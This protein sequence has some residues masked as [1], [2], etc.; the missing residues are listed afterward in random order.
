MASY[1]ATRSALWILG[2]RFHATRDASG[3]GVTLPCHGFWGYRAG[4]M[5]APRSRGAFVVPCHVGQRGYERTCPRTNKT[6]AT[7]PAFVCFMHMVG[8]GWGLELNPRVPSR[9]GWCSPAAVPCATWLGGRAG[10]LN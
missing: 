7:G 1:E 4:L 2:W 9:R 8:R 6:S 3:L 10:R 5:R